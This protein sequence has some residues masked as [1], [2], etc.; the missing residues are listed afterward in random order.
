MMPTA[1]FTAFLLASTQAQP[2]PLE[3]CTSYAELAETLMEGRQ[4]GVSMARAMDV[5]K[6]DPTV[7]KMVI[8]AYDEP[9]MSVE[10]NKRRAVEDFRDLIFMGCIKATSK[11]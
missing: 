4:A 7:S 11:P 6:D 3:V 2:T 9:R 1:L 5:A 8:M 10:E